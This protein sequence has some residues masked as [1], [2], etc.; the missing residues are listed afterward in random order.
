MPC[1]FS[2]CFKEYTALFTSV[3]R[4]RRQTPSHRCQPPFFYVRFYEDK[5]ALA[6]IDMNGAGTVGT[7]RWE[8]VLG[9]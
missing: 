3:W 2:A 9:L 7:D 5:P 4:W 6:E 1:S 8:E